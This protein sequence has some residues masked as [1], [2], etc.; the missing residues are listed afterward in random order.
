MDR[1]WS[2]IVLLIP[3]KSGKKSVKQDDTP[4]LF[5]FLSK[6]FT[7]VPS[8]L[9]QL[10]MDPEEYKILIDSLPQLENN[11]LIED[12][13]GK[14]L[15]QLLPYDST[16]SMFQYFMGKKRKRTQWI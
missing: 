2:D 14:Q 4:E 11:I 12:E 16:G 5:D 9:E 10:Y 7:N 13:T 8:E 3:T 1:N 6:N 15:V